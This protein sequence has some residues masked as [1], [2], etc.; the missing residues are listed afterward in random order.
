M[1]EG[2]ITRADLLCLLQRFETYEAMGST[3]LRN[4][5]KGLVDALRRFLAEA[6]LASIPHTRQGFEDWLDRL[7][8]QARKVLSASLDSPPCGAVRKGINLFLRGCVLNRYLRGA[9]RLD[10]I[11][12]WLEA[13]LDSVVTGKLKRRAGR[14]ALPVWRGMKHLTPADSAKFQ[15]FAAQEARR[16][17]FRSRAHL[18][19]DLWMAKR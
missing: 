10:R 12:P 14:G 18:D 16:R 11:E 9:Y 7:T 19:M 3:S 2:H 8:E 1:K 13:P 15:A 5:Q 4:Q 6:D 17:G